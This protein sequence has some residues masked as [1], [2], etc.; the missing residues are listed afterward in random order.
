MSDSPTVQ[1]IRLWEVQSGG[2]KEIERAKLD[3]EEKLEEWLE[4]DISMINEGLLVIGRQVPTRYGGRID[5][6][7]IDVDGNLILI[8]LKRDK[9]PREITSQVLD[10][11]SWVKELG[12]Q[13]VSEIAETYYRGKENNRTFSEIFQ[14]KFGA[15]IPDFIN[16]QHKMLVVGSEIDA[17][18]Q[19]IIQ[20]L[21][22]SG[23]DIN[24]LTFN[25]FNAGE[26]GFLARTFL[27]EPAQAESSRLQTNR[28]PRLTSEDLANT[29]EENGVGDVYRYLA[30]ELGHLFDSSRRMWG[31]IAYLGT[32]KNIK[33]ASIFNLVPNDGSV[34][35]GLRWQV[36]LL[37]FEEFFN[38]T[39]EEV[40]S[41]L[42]E[43]REKWTYSASSEQL[44]KEPEMWSGF[45]GYMNIE[46]AKQFID[47]LRK[48]TSLVKQ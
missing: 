21:V 27:I 34:E 20:Y 33:R 29:A 26:H 39:E 38:L 10:Y 22:E 30:K 42:P 8:E 47:R 12:S 7:C 17:S 13:D 3:L 18:S 23:V 4:A 45:T 2:I 19:R 46:E 14:S 1:A 6:L 44:E 31:S 48:A 32:V 35:H 36:Y 5:L 37:R 11:A 16:S 41:V 9:T 24:A 15:E 43:I 28:R 25:Y 40:L